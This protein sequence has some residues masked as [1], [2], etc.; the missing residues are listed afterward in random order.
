L[1]IRNRQASHGNNPSAQPANA[2]SS[3]PSVTPGP[4]ASAMVGVGGT[5][6][7]YCTSEARRRHVSAAHR[8]L[9]PLSVCQGCRCCLS[10]IAQS[11]MVRHAP[12]HGTVPRRRSDAPAREGARAQGG[13]SQ[14]DIHPRRRASRGQTGG[15][16][17]PWRRSPDL[18]DPILLHER[19]PEPWGQQRP[20]Q[21]RPHPPRQRLGSS[22]RSGAP[23]AMLSRSPPSPARR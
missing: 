23:R 3:K 12:D 19:L 22:Q 18:E 10:W 1:K 9:P 5:M 21:R 4:A 11:A 17:R 8:A 15:T 2:R 14:P 16:G 20:G 7:G 13:P 6:Y